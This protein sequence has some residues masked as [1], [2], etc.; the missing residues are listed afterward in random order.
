MDFSH[1]SLKLQKLKSNVSFLMYNT[2]F[3]FFPT[4]VLFS[5]LFDAIQQ[6]TPVAGTKSLYLKY[7]NKLFH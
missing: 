4:P 3:L 1:L 6:I 2:S 7:F 5:A